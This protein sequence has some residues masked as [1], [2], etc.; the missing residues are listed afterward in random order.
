MRGFYAI[1]APNFLSNRNN[2]LH[3]HLTNSIMKKVFTISALV[4][5]SFG[6][7]M[8]TNAE[9]ITWDFSEYTEQVDLGGDSYTTEYNG[10]TLV[11]NQG[12][13]SG[14]EYVS[15][16]AGFHCN[17]TSSATRRYISYVPSADGNMVVTFRSNNSSATDRLTAIGTAVVT[18][19]DAA[20]LLERAVPVNWREYAVAYLVPERDPSAREP[21]RLEVAHERAVL[22]DPQEVEARFRNIVGRAI[23]I[24][25]EEI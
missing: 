2:T 24:C 15:A 20:E 11:G 21:Y 5:A 1:F 23:D 25:G 9:V 12:A 18:G 4:A 19:S 6:I 8:N 3:N 14:K 7:A 10:L 17:G 22:P 16:A 13:D